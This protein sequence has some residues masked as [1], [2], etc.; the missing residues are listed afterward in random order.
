MKSVALLDNKKCKKNITLIMLFCLVLMLL[1]GCNAEKDSSTDDDFDESEWHKYSSEQI[2]EYFDDKEIGETIVFGKYEADN[3]EEN[4]KE[5][6]EWYILDKQEDKVLLFS[7][8]V[9]DA[10][11]YNEMYEGYLWEYST[12]RQWL[13]N[14]FIDTAFDNEERKLINKSELST[15]AN[16][17]KH[18]ETEDYVFLL[19]LEEAEQYI[20]LEKYIKGI[21][22]DYAIARGVRVSTSDEGAG[23]TD[24]WIRHPGFNN[25][26]STRDVAYV[27]AEG[28][29]DLQGE[30]A[31]FED[32]G[33]RP[34]L[35]VS[36]E[37]VDDKNE[38][39]KDS[40]VLEGEP[41][42]DEE[43]FAEL[44]ERYDEYEEENNESTDLQVCD[45]IKSCF[46][47]SLTDEYAYKEVVKGD[48]NNGI[49]IYFVDGKL[50]FDSEDTMPHVVVQLE[51]SLADLKP[52]KSNNMTCYYISWIL[53]GT[54]ID[55]IKVQTVSDYEAKEI[56]ENKS[57]KQP[58]VE[59]PPTI[60]A[61]AQYDNY[62]DAEK[63]EL[64]I[65]TPEMEQYILKTLCE[66]FDESHPEW[67][68][69]FSY[70]ICEEEDAYD[71]ILSDVNNV[72]D[73][74]YCESSKMSDLVEGGYALQISTII[75]DQIMENTDEAAVNS[76]LIDDML[77]GVPVY[78]KARLLY[79]NKS[80]IDDSINMNSLVN[81]KIDGCRYNLSFPIHDYRY[82]SAFYLG[83]R[84]LLEQ[85]I[86]T[87][88]TFSYDSEE[89][90]AITNYLSNLINSGKF[91]DDDGS[92][93][94]I[95][96][97][98]QEQLAAYIS[99]PEKALDIKE[100]LGDNYGVMLLPQMHYGVLD[101]GETKQ[102][103]PFAEYGVIA[104][105]RSTKYYFVSTQLV[106]FLAS[107]YAQEVRLKARS[108]VPTNNTVIEYVK[109]GNY[110]DI[111]VEAGVK[112]IEFLVEL[113][114]YRIMSN[115]VD[116]MKVLGKAIVNQ[117]AE[118]VTNDATTRKFLKKIDEIIW[119]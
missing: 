66:Q 112:Q 108:C 79:Y 98:R 73:V 15:S 55:D 83:R 4:G 21:P 81:E 87:V 95:E 17:G 46:N 106:E 8:Y 77:Y 75:Q 59:V 116:A 56:R 71:K 32:Y 115:Y 101:E 113:P 50:T 1:V 39:N 3:D 74:F 34:A 68:I 65:W 100:A 103:T 86:N 47:A 22:T 92:G 104:A 25:M 14:D 76:C 89:G 62:V 12:I 54:Y 109:A 119:K 114:N 58:T 69:T 29:L 36:L 111:G 52:P 85:D 118:V 27:S 43:W 96:L 61:P 72:A 9:L 80:L 57:E 6:I 41:E 117:D 63:V 42:N 88:E 38:D 16:D 70:E 44:L 5:D 60:E 105:N 110:G 99:G 26:G 82:L 48:V 51:A 90:V 67:D 13:N 102:I 30:P 7:K 78:S 20:T 49:L 40:Q 33:I 2:K 64:T 24:W 11:K 35:W 93:K 31:Y 84:Y 37:K 91:V 45:I 94:V 19:S 53:D 23:M 107:D 18:E 28:S 10:N 97:L